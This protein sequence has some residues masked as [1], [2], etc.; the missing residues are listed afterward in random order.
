MDVKIA[1]AYKWVFK[2]KLLSIGLLERYKARLVA[3]GFLQTLGIDYK[4]NFIPIIK[5]TIIQIVLTITISKGRRDCQ[6]DVN[7]AFIHGVLDE[8]VYMELPPGYEVSSRV[9]CLKKILYGFKQTRLTWFVRLSSSC[10]DWAS[11]ALRLFLHYF[12]SILP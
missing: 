6:V 4:K 3:C 5:A 11:K 12:C 8:E 7:N 2:C 1:I 10:W 9:Y